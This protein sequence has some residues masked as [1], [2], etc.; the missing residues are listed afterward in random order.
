M[1]E[2]SLAIRVEGK[3][4]TRSLAARKAIAISLTPA[5]AKAK[6]V[7]FQMH[8][9]LFIIT[10]IFVYQSTCTPMEKRSTDGNGLGPEG[11]AGIVIGVIGLIL[12]ALAVLK[13]WECWKSRRVILSLRT[14]VASK[15]LKNSC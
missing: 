7:I 10:V 8:R 11:I 3:S 12:S 14:H 5:K 1:V 15:V 13:G 9:V 2:R 6:H 4:L